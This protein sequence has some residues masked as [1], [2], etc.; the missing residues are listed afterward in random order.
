[1]SRCLFLGR[2]SSTLLRLFLGR[3]QQSQAVSGRVRRIRWLHV[4]RLRH[5]VL[6]V[7]VLRDLLEPLTEA[8]LRLLQIKHRQIGQVLGLFLLL[9]EDAVQCLLRNDLVEQLDGVQVP[10]L[11]HQDHDVH[12]ALRDDL[13]EDL[14]PLL[15]QLAVALC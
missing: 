1:M 10:I 4:R 5:L 7:E 13:A 3:L 14:G 2:Q 15:D 12:L 9:Q 11:P 6:V 8:L